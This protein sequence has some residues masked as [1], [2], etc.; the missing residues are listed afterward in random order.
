MYQKPTVEKFGSF[1][2]LTRVGFAG[3]S[4]G[5]TF[6]GAPDGC[7]GFDQNGQPYDYCPTAS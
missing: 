7:T 3:S 2:E 1:R 4:D 6:V 5:G